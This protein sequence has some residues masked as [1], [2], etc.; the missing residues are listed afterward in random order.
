MYNLKKSQEVHMA[1]KMDVFTKDIELS[2]RLN[3]YVTKKV[4][5]LERYLNEIGE[6]RVDLASSKSARNL[7]DRSIAQITIRGRGFI[8]RSEERAESIYSAI[9]AS[10]DKMKSQIERFKGKHWTKKV[11]GVA[12]IADEVEEAE[13]GE[14]VIVRRKS[15][16]LTPMDELEALEQL[17]LLGHENFFVFF[18]SGTDKINVLYKR[19]DGTYGLIDPIVG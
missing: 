11:E 9:D 13:Q 8:L 3:D 18:N 14:P 2:D 4:G 7:A 19:R 15:F 5:K 17:Q 16:Q 6:C 1:M 12:E 10:V